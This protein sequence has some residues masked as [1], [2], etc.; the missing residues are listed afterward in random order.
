MGYEDTNPFTACA[1]VLAGGT[2][3]NWKRTQIGTAGSRHRSLKMPSWC[4]V[5]YQNRRSKRNNSKL[6]F[7]A[8]PI[9]RSKDNFGWIWLNER[10]GAGWSSNY[11]IIG[12]YCWKKN[13]WKQILN[14]SWVTLIIIVILK[15]IYFIF[16][17]TYDKSQ[18]GSCLRFKLASWHFHSVIFLM[19]TDQRKQFLT[20]RLLANIPKNT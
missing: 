8:M 20:Y 3:Q 9:I 16:I 14:L 5:G 1:K 18:N 4:I 6:K 2:T 17:I 12:S 15:N 7:C 11:Q 10:T 13:R 19:K